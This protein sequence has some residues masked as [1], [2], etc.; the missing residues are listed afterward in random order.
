MARWVVKCSE[1]RIRWTEWT[2]YS[3]SF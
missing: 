2:V 3:F 1:T